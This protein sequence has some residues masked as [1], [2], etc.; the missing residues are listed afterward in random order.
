[1]EQFPINGTDGMSSTM[2]TLYFYIRDL[3]FPIL[4]SAYLLW[5][6]TG[7]LE[8][9]NATLIKQGELLSILIKNVDILLNIGAR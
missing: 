9:I 5:K 2:R 1:M 3:G 6:I 4:V 7:I 8:E